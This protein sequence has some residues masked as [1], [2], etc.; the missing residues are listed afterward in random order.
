MSALEIMGLWVGYNKGGS[1]VKD[2]GIRI[3]EGEI[4]G[5]IGPNG[6]GKT[7]LLKTICGVLHPSAGTVRIWNEDVHDEPSFRRTARGVA[8]V[9]E[10]ARVFVDLTVQENLLMGAYRRTDKTEI[11][12]DL[13]V[14]FS[15]FPQ[16]RD[17][18]EARAG[19]LSG[20][21]RQMLAIG[22]GLMSRAPLVMLDEPSLGLAP[23]LVDEVFR[24]LLAIR[25]LGTTLLLVEQ[26]AVKAFEVADRVY[27]LAEGAVV[28][29]GKAQDLARDPYIVD[30]YFGL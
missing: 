23:L 6:A 22:R 9:P 17:R 13:E 7:T 15:L 1:V 14:V 18:T 26:N 10:G 24:T 3:D 20:G 28:M 16:L 4:V 5:V 29:D 19:G 21:Q 8:M 25:D 30:S 27:V 2:V 11:S 12:E